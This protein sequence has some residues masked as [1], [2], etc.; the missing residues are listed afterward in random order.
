[1]NRIVSLFVYIYFVSLM[2]LN[3]QRNKAQA[4]QLACWM[5]TLLLLPQKDSLQYRNYKATV[6]VVLSGAVLDV[7]VTEGSNT[8]FSCGG[9]YFSNT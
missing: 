9:F 7:F 3:L 2:D 1:M 5:V 6:L 4:M 8:F